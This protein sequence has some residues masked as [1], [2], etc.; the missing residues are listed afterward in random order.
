VTLIVIP[1]L[2]IGGAERQLVYLATGLK[3]RGAPVHVA[4]LYGGGAFES[5]LLKAGVPVHCLGKQRPLSIVGPFLRLRRLM[6]SLEPKVVHG[7]LPLPN[8]MVTLAPGNARRVWGICIAGMLDQPLRF[9]ERVLYWA[10]RRLANRADTIIACSRAGEREMLACGTSQEKIAF[11]PNGYDHVE[12]RPDAAQGSRVRRGFGIPEDVPVFGVIGRHDRHKNHQL[13]LRAFA[14]LD[15]PEA[16][17]LLVGRHTGLQ[18]NRL[19]ALA[20]ELGI[21]ERVVWSGERED[22]P[23]VMNALSVLVSVSLAEGHP[24]I[25]AEAMLSG[26][27][28]VVSDVGDCAAMVADLGEV[29]KFDVLDVSRGMERVLERV[30]TGGQAYWEALRASIIERF[31]TERLLD[32]VMEVLYEFKA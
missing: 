30:V 25:V 26:V 27:P 22:M 2:E 28:C 6:D 14:Q 19:K 32:R 21:S 13:A 16:R 3:E 1:S 23:A 7:I 17:L 18:T 10:E 31:S 4:T 11:V 5:E 20:L 15:C 12:F 9:R 8:L 24:N 29:V